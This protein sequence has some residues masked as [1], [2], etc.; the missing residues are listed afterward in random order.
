MSAISQ[1]A[2]IPRRSVRPKLPCIEW[3]EISVNDRVICGG[4]TAVCATIVANKKAP[5]RLAAKTTAQ[6]PVTLPK[7][8]LAGCAHKGKMTVNV[9]PVKELRRTRI[10]DK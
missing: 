6:S 5:T 7:V 4:K 10:T 9:V 2:N 8:E 3:R 1:P